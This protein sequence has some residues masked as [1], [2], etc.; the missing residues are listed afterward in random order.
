MRKVVVIGAD[1]DVDALERAVE[2]TIKRTVKRR[3]NRGSSQKHEKSAKGNFGM[4][5]FRSDDVG[6]RVPPS[7]SG[8]KWWRRYAKARPK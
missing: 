8:S 7:S 3:W 1:E 6:F 2:M 5:D 4:V